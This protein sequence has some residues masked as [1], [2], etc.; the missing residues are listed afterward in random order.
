ML[1]RLLLVDDEPAILQ[2]YQRVLHREFQLETATSGADALAKI[3][4]HPYA[5]VVSD[6]RMPEMDGVQ[7]LAKIKI[8]SPDTIRVMLTG[9]ADIETAIEAVNEGNIFRFL[10]KPCSKE[11]LAKTLTAGLVQY[12]LVTAEKELLEQTLRG[13]IQVLTD[14]LSLVNPAAFSRAVRVRKY[15][16]HVVRVMALPNAWMFEV[17]AMMSQLGCVTLHPDTVEAVYAGKP[18]SA[19]EQ[20]RVNMHPQI[21]GDLL[22]H[23]PRMEPIAWMISHQTDSTA[24]DEH[25][26][27]QEISQAIRHGADILRATLR[28]DEQLQR[29][30]AKASVL[31]ELRTRWSAIDQKIFL[32]LADVEAEAS[33]SKMQTTTFDVLSVGMTINEEVRTKNG[34]L[35]VA[36]G[37]E[38]TFPLIVKLKNFL[39][40]GEI[41]GKVSVS[42][43]KPPVAVLAAAR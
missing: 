21:G 39:E 43:P 3:A 1:E 35:I 15:V 41:F 20:A 30:V 29:G 9:N 12:R 33:Q 26:P 5:V 8:V 36:K 34:L 7:L 27:A 42:V 40:K 19:D 11:T 31:K 16:N 4:A 2:G 18:I 14:V 32:A 28:F 24:S 23:I 13:S 22:A 17:A 38:V 6:M 37:Q 25:D 10:T